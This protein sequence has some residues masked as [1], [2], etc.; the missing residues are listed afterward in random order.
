MKKT[1]P[2]LHLSM[3]SLAILA[4]VFAPAPARADQATVLRDGPVAYYRLN[5]PTTRSNV[6]LNAGSLGAA[7]AATNVNTHLIPGAIVGSH[8]PATYFDSTAWTTVPWNA[9]LNPNATNSFTIEAWFYPTSD[10][11][12][13]S[14]AG[15]APIMNRYSYSGVN[16][17]GWVYFQRNPNSTY[18]T[19][20]ETR[21]G[22]TFATYTGNGSNVGINLASGAPYRLGQWQHVVTVWD[23]AAQTATMY[24][25]GVQAATGGNTSSDPKAYVANSNDHPASEAPNG[26]AGFTI[27]SYNN[28]APGSN[29]F[30]GGVDE[31]AFYAKK[32]T[33]AQILAHYQNATNAA[34]AVAYEQLVQ[35]D[36]P[37]LYLRL[38]DRAPGPDVAVNLGS[39]QASGMAT[40]T[41]DV[42]HPV[43]GAVVGS[44]SGGAASYH[45]RNGS[46]TT[47]IP[48]MADNNPP[49]NEPFSVEA[50][51]RATSDRQNPGAAPINNRYVQSGNRTGWVFFQ[52]APNATYSSTS[53][54]SGVGWNFRMYSGSGS[55][56][57][58]VTSGVDYTVGEW[59]HVVAT[60]DGGNGEAIYING[61]LA[62]TNSAA[63]YKANTNPTEDNSPPADLAIGSYNIASGIGANAFE[64]DVADVAIYKTLLTPDQILAHYQAGTNYNRGTNYE[65][66]VLTAPYDQ[67]GTQALQPA[68]YLRLDEPAYF[69]AGNSG[70]L[71]DAASGVMMDTT[72]SVAGLTNAGFEL[73]N[74]AAPF[75]GTSGW[76][77]FDNPSGLNISNRISLEA[78]IKPDATQGTLARVISHGPPT[79]TSYPDPT[80]VVTNGSVY[81]GSEVFLRLENN[82]ANYAFGASDGTNTHSVSIAVPAGDLGGGKWI[83]LVGVYDGAHWNLYR[84]GALA[85][86]TTD[87]IG[88]LPVN[89]AGWATGSTGN[90]W[91]DFFTGTIDEVAIYNVALTAGQVAAHYTFN[92]AGSG[93]LTVTH[94][95]AAVT[96]TYVAGTLQQA[97]NV[98]GPFADV[99]GASSPFHPAAGTSAKFYRLKF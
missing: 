48:W 95:G 58:D 35:S 92:P 1:V 91:D 43:A 77:S 13:G 7:G 75:N 79:I 31:V 76:V 50:W 51:F 21:V 84:N 70:S 73:A 90:G 80:L 78:W 69:P 52:R 96:V 23:G 34:R 6:N 67:S 88:A 30:R 20:G 27:G 71:G 36:G 37:T 82:G 29:P 97:D 19:D 83:Q 8:N 60:W 59:Q 46:A 57:Q 4:C 14:F 66:L 45:Y 68:T 86:S 11:V 38:D 63:I 74:L 99:S 12:A 47:D 18:S 25:D 89:N 49:E 93:A 62:A 5:D 87:P 55:G 54:Y 32:L 10:K 22:W 15:P 61:V 40:N 56:G 16:R 2:R 17:Q 41:A 44:T 26:P 24:I 3:A 65:T 53:G 42:R 98:T 81:A 94:A 85:N 72:A 28:T 33:A 64:G 39:L 9:A